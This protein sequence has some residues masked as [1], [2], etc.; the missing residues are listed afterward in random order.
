[1]AEPQDG[2]EP[3]TGQEHCPGLLRECE[4]NFYCVEVSVHF[5]GLF[6]QMC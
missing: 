5:G 2:R 3:L 1:M 6:V 4:K